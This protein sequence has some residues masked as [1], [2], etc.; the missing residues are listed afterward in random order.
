MRPTVGAKPWL[1]KSTLIKRV[2]LT[3]GGGERDNGRVIVE[4]GP[5]RANQKQRTRMAIVAAA[6]DLTRTGSELT[7]PVIARAALVSEATAY[8]YFPDLFSLLHEAFAG[9]WP[10]PAESMAP[11]ADCAD[12]VERVACAAE[13]LLRGVWARQ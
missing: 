7:M 3:D 11:V 8:R 13:V 5:G 4:S 12:V 2:N 10:A 9:S 6:R 1:C